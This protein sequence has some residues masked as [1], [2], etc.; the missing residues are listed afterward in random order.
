MITVVYPVVSV[1][2][3]NS[4]DIRMP[5]GFAYVVVVVAS[6]GVD[7]IN[8]Q[9]VDLLVTLARFAR[10]FA[11][12]TASSC[13]VDD[14]EILSLLCRT[15]TETTT[16]NPRK[17]TTNGL[18]ENSTEP[19]RRPAPL[20]IAAGATLGD[21][22]ES[23]SACGDIAFECGTNRLMSGDSVCIVNEVK[24]SSYS[25]RLTN[26]TTFTKP[27]IK[28]KSQCSVEVSRQI[29]YRVETARRHGHLRRQRLRRRKEY[30]Y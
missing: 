4:P 16:T 17:S 28:Q 20:T 23:T 9:S 14:K 18:S 26:G 27:E 10:L 6:R 3:A 25:R 5:L 29:E 1:T 22:D 15:K 8:K 19:R 30:C 11:A 2:G 13:S 24:K 21:D 12:R 7:K